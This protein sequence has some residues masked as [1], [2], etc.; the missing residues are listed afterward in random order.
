MNHPIGCSA[1]GAIQPFRVMAVQ[2]SSISELPVNSSMPWSPDR[3]G[4]CKMFSPVRNRP[5]VMAK[6]LQQVM[7]LGFT[8]TIVDSGGPKDPVAICR[9]LDAG[10]NRQPH[11]F[12]ARGP[13]G[14]SVIKIGG[15]SNIP[16]EGLILASGRR[17]IESCAW[18]E[19]DK[20]VLS[21]TEIFPDDDRTPKAGHH[22][23]RV[24]IGV[25]VWTEN[26]AKETVHAD[27]T[28]F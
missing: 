26:L 28:F 7:P 13:A 21:N 8:G 15:A 2:I 16:I 6:I 19:S 1:S 9:V 22:G 25:Y 4:K 23:G 18:M 24:N 27:R 10:G 12:S 20:I 17:D 11:K 3:T 14:T 5:S